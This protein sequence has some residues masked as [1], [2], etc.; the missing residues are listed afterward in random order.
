MGCLF[1]TVTGCC[2][3]VSLTETDLIPQASPSG[4]F[5][6]DARVRTL[7]VIANEVKQSGW[8]RVAFAQP[9]HSVLLDSRLR[10]QSPPC[11]ND[12]KAPSLP[13]QPSLPSCTWQRCATPGPHVPKC[14]LGTSA[15]GFR[16]QYPH[17]EDNK[18]P[19]TPFCD[20]G[21]FRGGCFSTGVISW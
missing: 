2:L 12:G 6:R 20:A 1:A 11:G 21:P 17:K 3:P 9:G 4:P 16:L 14:N 5:P 13:P 7:S 18:S 15:G 10:R 8:G 19:K